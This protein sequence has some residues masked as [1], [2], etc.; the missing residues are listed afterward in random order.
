MSQGGPAALNGELEGGSPIF[1]ATP[2]RADLSLRGRGR[3]EGGSHGSDSQTHAVPPKADCI[4][5][6]E[7]FSTCSVLLGQFPGMLN[8]CFFK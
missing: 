7:G 5:L 2:R 6:D 3:A 4:S 1:S 8:G